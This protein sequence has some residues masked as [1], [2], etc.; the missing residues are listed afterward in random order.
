MYNELRNLDA[1]LKGWKRCFRWSRCKNVRLLY[2]VRTCDIDLAFK[3]MPSCLLANRFQLNQEAGRQGVRK[4]VVRMEK[5]GRGSG[6]EKGA[7]DKDMDLLS[8]LCRDSHSLRGGPLR[9]R[10]SF[11]ES[12]S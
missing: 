12:F 2:L 11:L 4:K 3:I 6:L 1:T 10:E 9:S 5:S 8:L 7:R